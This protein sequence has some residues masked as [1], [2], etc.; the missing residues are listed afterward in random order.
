MK[1][2]TIVLFLPASDVANGCGSLRCGARVAH[3]GDD[4]AFALRAGDH[5][6]LVGGQGVAAD[7][8]HVE[9]LVADLAQQQT[10]LGWI[11]AEIDHIDIGGVQPAHQRAVVDIPG[12]D[13]LESY[14]RD[15]KRV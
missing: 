13:A 4:C 5:P 11:P 2:S 10:R 12:R 6:K 3:E 1:S 15:P 9:T 8:L 14:L 7:K